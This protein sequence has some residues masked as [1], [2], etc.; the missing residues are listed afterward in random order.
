MYPQILL[1]FIWIFGFEPYVKT[2][3]L[4]QKYCT[5]AVQLA[6]FRTDWISGTSNER[7]RC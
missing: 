1:C 2:S 5:A 3:D 6:M 4:F 7:P